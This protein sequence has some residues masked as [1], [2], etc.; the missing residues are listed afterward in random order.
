MAAPRVQLVQS[1]P[2]MRRRMRRPQHTFQLRTRPWQIQPFL[3]APVL[4]G[5]TLENITLQSS[6]V[7]DPIKNKLIGWWNEYHFFYVKHRD[8]DARDEIVSMHLKG[9]A[10]MAGRL[11]APNVDTYGFKGAIDWTSLCLKRVVEEYFRNEGEAWDA[12][13]IGNLPAAQIK[14]NSFL[15]SVISDTATDTPNELQNPSTDNSIMASY[16]EHYDRM[17]QMRMTDMSF[18]DWLRTHGVNGVVSPEPEDFYKPEL[19]RSVREYAAPNNTVDPTTGTP[20]TA[21]VWRHMITAN[22][23]RWFKEPGFILGVTV[24]RPKVYMWPQK[25]QAVGALDTA[26]LWLPALLRDEPYTSLKEF[27]TGAATMNGPLGDRPTGD[28][29]LDMR[30][31]FLYGDQFAN[32]D[33]SDANANANAIG[34][35]DASLQK[36]YANAAQADALFVNAGLNLVR[37]D[38]VCRL[39]IK[40]TVGPDQ[41]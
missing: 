5:E 24:S 27:K 20:T 33:L 39:H 19:L 11:A 3:C 40:G 16:Q 2:V 8:L 21:M 7:S 35:P 12:F 18:D 17:R 30:D 13:K 25:G 10:L 4:A 14:Q 26:M 28:Y 41:T 15:D 37:Q 34:L 31:L 22:K 36:T 23:A 6:V 1:A 32:F 9:T 29:W 38:G